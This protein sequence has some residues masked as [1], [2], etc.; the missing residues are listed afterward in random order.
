MSDSMVAVSAHPRQD[1]PRQALIFDADDTLWITQWLY[2]QAEVETRLIVEAAGLDGDRWSEL[3][4]SIDRENVGAFG[5]HAGR[6]PTSVVQAYVNRSAAEGRPFDSRVAAELQKA[7]GSVFR[8][9]APLAPG[10]REILEQLRPHYRLILMTKGD[11]AVQRKRIADSGLAR[12]FDVIR[13]VKEKDQETFRRI[14]AD[15]GVT[16]RQCW[17]VGNSLPSDI[18]PALSLGMRGVWVDAHSWDYEKRETVPLPG[19][20]E[21]LSRIRDLPALLLQ[22]QRPAPPEQLAV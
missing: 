4:K 12:Y 6:F 8:R 13:I 16:P 10:A 22:H 21:R 14:A 9:K 18:N 17:S 15:A 20:L 19:R 11:E 2:D 1:P 3:F 7:A 5:Y